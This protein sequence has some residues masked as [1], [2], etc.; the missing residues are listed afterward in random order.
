[1]I[2]F[3]E[4]PGGGLAV[5]LDEEQLG[6]RIKVIGVGGGGGNAVNRMIQAGIKGIEFMVA[7][8]DV[9]AMRNSLAPVKLQIGG[10]LTKGLG[11]GANPEI[12]KQAALEDTD[13]I[14][15]ALSGADMIFIT[16]GM[17]GGT[18]TGAAPIIAS[19]AAELGALTVAVVTKPFGFE[20]KRRRIQAE[21]GIRSL[22]ETVDTL[23]TIPNER[24]LNFVERATSLNEAFTIAD[25]ILRQAVQGISDLITV[26][27]E[28]N[29]DFA[30]VKTIMHGM[31]MAL[32]GT[33][34]SSGEHRAVEAAQR[35]ISSP[36][37]EEASIEGAKG[38][39][40]NITGGPDMTLFEVH[41]AASIIQEAAD[42]EANII[43]GTVI[44]PR[45]KDEVKVTVIATGFDSATKGFLNTRGEQL[46]SGNARAASGSAPAPFRP[47]APKEIAAQHEVAP[48]VAAQPQVGAEGEIYD[49][50]FFRK[51]FS[52]PDGSGGFGPMASSDFG[53]DLDIPTVIRNLSD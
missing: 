31:G 53:N 7:N 47:F 19:L 5:T 9:Q 44:D 28:I 36:L 25:D 45:M 17:G 34:V 32:M 49:P 3:D 33:G 4:K 48:E 37:L 24:L 35:A 18:G 16:T 29:L 2:T 38:V 41:E 27:G 50:P 52:R 8:T 39:L 12:G 51:G 46:S 22:R 30:D 13:R 43:F 10:K 21:Q 1:M 26:P 20:G 11:A 14:L 6:A 15:E 23:I 42:E 40:I